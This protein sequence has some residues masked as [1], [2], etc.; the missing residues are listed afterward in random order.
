MKPNLYFVFFVLSII[1]QPDALGQSRVGAVE[2]VFTPGVYSFHSFSLTR[3]SVERKETL[4]SGGFEGKIFFEQDTLESN[5]FRSGFYGVKDSLDE[6][7]WYKRILG[8]GY[9]QVNNALALEDGWLITGVFSDTIQLGDHQYVS[10]QYQN[11]FYAKVNHDGDV[12]FSEV[13]EVIA[14]GGKQFLTPGRNGYFFFATEFVGKFSFEDTLY[15]GKNQSVML[16][17]INPEGVLINLSN[18]SSGPYIE[19]GAFESIQGERLLLGINFKDTLFINNDIFYGDGQKD[20][21]LAVLNANLDILWHKRSGEAGE[22]AL[23]G[24]LSHPGGFVAF[25][26]YTG[27]FSLDSIVYNNQDGRHLF[28]TKFTLGGN[29]VWSQTFEGQSDKG[30]GGLIKNHENQLYAWANF[31]GKLSINDQVVET[32]E[33]AYE[34]FLA[35]ISPEGELLWVSRAGNDQNISSGLT[36]GFEPGTF[37]VFG[38]NRETGL[39]FFN[40]PFEPQTQ[41]KFELKLKD[42]E[43]AKGPALPADTVFCG[44]GTLDAGL[45]YASY[46]WNGGTGGNEF[47]VYETGLVTLEVSDPFGCVFHDTTFVEILPDFEIQITGNDQICPEGGN[48]LLVVD[49]NAEITWNTGETGNV[50]WVNQPGTYYAYAIDENGCKAEDNMTVS[51]YDVQPV[52]LNEY[53][54]LSPD[55]TL[56]L[57]PGEYSSY[58]WSDGT[59]QPVLLINGNSI[60]EGTF[61]Y[62]LQVT[63]FRER[64]SLIASNNITLSFVS[65]VSHFSYKFLLFRKRFIDFPKT[66]IV[67]CTTVLPVYIFSVVS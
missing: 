61:L 34:W 49:S 62:S 66:F 53:Y 33:F 56:E 60:G 54:N 38:T 47:A 6:W 51:Y 27:P 37:S 43:S 46:L 3:G 63:V 42:C 31:R 28:L 18:I 24:A 55:Q 14:N 1:L 23:R 58:A 39:G 15:F 59:T 30:F 65:I 12:V 64:G 44:F 36:A 22:K 2:P 21:F 17:L 19:V 13:L 29:Q 40:F 26:E 50:N 9:S 25:G 45:N 16:G 67:F 5:T 10:S 4:F 11:V 57:Y 8:Q 52:L 35:K 48:S 20:F 41:S 32:E 7:S